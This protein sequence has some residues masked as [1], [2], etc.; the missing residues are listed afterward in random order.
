MRM[1]LTSAV[2]IA[3]AVAVVVT[4]AAPARAV[5]TG[6]PSVRVTPNDEFEIRWTANFVGD[7]RVDLFT[8]PDGT[9]LIDVKTGLAN[10]AG[11]T[12]DFFVGGILT[13]D[14]TYYFKVLHRD[15]TN[16]RPDLTNEPPPFPPVFTGVQAISGVSV[17]PGTETALISWDANVIGFGQVDYGLTLFPIFGPV[18]AVND[19]L[20]I[21]N[22]AIELTGLSPGTA[23]QYR[24][25]NRHAI[26]GDA[27][28]EQIGSFTTAVPEPGSLGLMLLGVF[29]LPLIRR[30]RPQQRPLGE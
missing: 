1:N 2:V 27:L 3:A 16:V 5:F 8:N 13:P 21:T 14:T 4:V 23:Y 11:H 18:D 29:G 19:N 17:A 9:G 10:A 22:H 28:V 6:G 30:R 7:G 15:P 24:V 20:N 12:V 26:D 25:S